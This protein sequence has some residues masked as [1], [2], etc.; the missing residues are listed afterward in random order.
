MLCFHYKMTPH[1]VEDLTL[2][3]YNMLIRALNDHFDREAK[4]HG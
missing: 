4:A 2:A 1:Q 3:Q